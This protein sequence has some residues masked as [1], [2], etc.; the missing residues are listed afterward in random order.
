VIVHLVDGTFELFRQFYGR[1]RGG[2][3]DK[4]MGAVIG[5]L[6]SVLEM[7]EK[8]ASMTAREPTRQRILDSAIDLFGTRG[9]DVIESVEEAGQ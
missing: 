2:R 1:R 5:V 9:V 4:P 3:S 6:H 8:G 7:V